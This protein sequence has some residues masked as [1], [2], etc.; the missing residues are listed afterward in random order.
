[1][2]RN[3]G[4][5]EAAD[6]GSCSLRSWRLLRQSCSAEHQTQKLAK[7]RTALASYLITKGWPPFL[8]QTY[9]HLT[10][11]L[12]SVPF[13]EMRFLKGRKPN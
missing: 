1:M 12:S 6:R 2:R 9:F 11:K 8:S 5:D 7:D 10:R 3:L 4:A 13:Y